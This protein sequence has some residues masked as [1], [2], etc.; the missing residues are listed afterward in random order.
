[1]VLLASLISCARPSASIPYN[2]FVIMR[3]RKTFLFDDELALIGA[4]G[5]FVRDC[6]C[7]LNCIGLIN[8]CNIWLLTYTLQTA[9]GHHPKAR[10]LQAAKLILEGR[11]EE[12]WRG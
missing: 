11:A 10:S 3:H 5:S 12:E 8:A 1:V 7:Q 2:A 4:A 9:V 6:M